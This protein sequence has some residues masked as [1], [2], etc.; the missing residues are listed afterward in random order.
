MSDIAML[1]AEEY[2]RRV[3]KSRRIGG[4]SEE[5]NLFSSVSVFARRVEWSS[6]I[7]KSFGEEKMELLLKWAPEPKSPIGVAAING[8]FSA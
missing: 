8:F 1:V 6:W 3:K 2:E 5:I 7:K 4:E